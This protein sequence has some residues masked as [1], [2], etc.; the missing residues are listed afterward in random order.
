MGTGRLSVRIIGLPTGG[1]ITEAGDYSLDY[2]A[3]ATLVNRWKCRMA[4]KSRGHS[5]EKRIPNSID[6]C[7]MLPD[8]SQNPSVP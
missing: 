6:H 5:P 3:T 2:L 7:V 8:S 4:L 1:R